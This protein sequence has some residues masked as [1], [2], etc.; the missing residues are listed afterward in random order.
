M[1]QFK[2]ITSILIPMIYLFISFQ[3]LSSLF[4]CFSCELF[5]LIYHLLKFNIRSILPGIIKWYQIVLFVAA[6]FINPELSC[7]PSLGSHYHLFPW[8]YNTEKIMHCFHTLIIQKLQT[9]YYIYLIFR[10]GSVFMFNDISF[11]FSGADHL[12]MFTFHLFAMLARWRE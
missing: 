2:C 3:C 6:K 7:K 5:V 4:R 8:R 10:I 11:M 9:L 1:C 12:C